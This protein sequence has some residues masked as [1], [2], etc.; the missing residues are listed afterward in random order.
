MKYEVIQL[1]HAQESYSVRALC[2]IFRGQV[3][4]YYAW[5]RSPV[6]R[7][8]QADAQWLALIGTLFQDHRQRLGSPRVHALLRQQ[9]YR[10]SRKRVARLMRQ[11]GWVAVH[12]RRFLRPRTTDSQHALPVAP[13]RLNRCFVAQRPNEKWVSDLTYLR[14]PEGWLYLAVIVD[15]F[16]RR[17]VGWSIGKDRA[18]G[19][20]EMALRRAWRHRQPDTAQQALLHHSDRGSPYASAVYQARLETYGMQASMSGV[21]CVYDNTLMESFFAT[22]KAD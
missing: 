11:E 7:R 14:S 18:T 17:V 19:L 12:K 16:S 9:G 15:V 21:G 5:C 8:A 6:S 10:I 4:G 13:N 22:L 1:L 20:T 3:S 2:Q